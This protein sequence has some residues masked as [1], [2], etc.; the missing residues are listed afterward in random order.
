LLECS[1]LGPPLVADDHKEKGRAS[2]TCGVVIQEIMDIPTD[3]PQE[4]PD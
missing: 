2:K 3:I 4:T 1:F